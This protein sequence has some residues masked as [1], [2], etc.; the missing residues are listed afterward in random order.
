MDFKLLDLLL[1]PEAHIVA[2]FKDGML[3]LAVTYDGVDLGGEA[4]ILV[5]TRACLEKLKEL[6]PGKIDDALIS[7][8]E[9]ALGL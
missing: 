6:I 5:K 2:E 7:L 8:A 3:Q 9:Q 1:G 4:K